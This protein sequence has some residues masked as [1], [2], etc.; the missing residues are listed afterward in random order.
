MVFRVGGGFWRTRDPRLVVD[1]A[2]SLCLGSR[3]L[4]LGHTI[5]ALGRRLFFE[6]A[7]P[8]TWSHQLAFG[9]GVRI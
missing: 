2:H 9:V 4:I 8:Y 6:L 5:G 3:R 1:A 7:M